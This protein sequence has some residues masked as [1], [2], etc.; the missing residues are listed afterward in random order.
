M[1]RA[2]HHLS[3]ELAVH[4]QFC[5]EKRAVI[6]YGLLAIFNIA[7]IGISISLISIIFHIWYESIT[8]FLGVGILK[9]STGG[10]HAHSMLS[11]AVVSVISI[12]GF[13]LTA[14]YALDEPI[15]LYINIGISLL[16]FVLSLIIFN[17]SVPLDTPNKPIKKPEKIKRLRG[18]SFFLL[19]LYTALSIATGIM[20]P[21]WDRFGSLSFCL[22]FVLLWQ[23]L[24]LTQYGQRFI[25]LLTF[26]FDVKEVK[27]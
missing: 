11:C 4:M 18:Q 24:M 23:T 12:T 5:E 27:K 8:I 25:S 13:A 21:I 1:E 15:N 2:A 16:V 10:A 26:K 17:R 22:R 19:G 3:E 20:A 14:R 6:E 7:V 9:K